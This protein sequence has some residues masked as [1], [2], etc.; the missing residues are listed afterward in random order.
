MPKIVGKWYTRQ[1]IADGDGI[2]C[3]MHS[4]CVGSSRDDDDEDYEKDWCYCVQ[5]SY[6][7]MIIKPA[8]FSGFTVNALESEENLRYCPGCAKMYTKT[9]KKTNEE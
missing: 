2:V 9:K 8:Q 6:G 4:K 7:L 3:A 1:L 5:P